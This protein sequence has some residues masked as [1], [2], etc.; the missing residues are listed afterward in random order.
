MYHSFRPG[1]EWLD[2]NGKPIQAHGGSVFFENGT[3]YW[4]GENK[5]F[6]DGK[7]GVWTWGVRCYSS[8]DLYNWKDEGLIIPPDEKDETSPLHPTAMLDRPHILYNRKTKQYVCWCKIMQTNG[9][10]TETVLTADTILG[11]YTVKKTGLKPLGMSA[12]DF[13]L[14]VAPDGKGYYFFERVHSEDRKSVV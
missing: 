10:Q 5:E 7:N 9:E 14:A 13:D 8:Q 4:Y 2:T 3:Y 6:T 12:G 11:P 1:E